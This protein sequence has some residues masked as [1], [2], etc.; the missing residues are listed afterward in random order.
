MSSGPIPLPGNIV[1]ACRPPYFAFG[2]P[3]YNKHNISSAKFFW[4]IV[5]SLI[6]EATWEEFHQS[7]KNAMK[8][9]Q[10]SRYQST[11]KSR[12]SEIWQ[13]IN[14]R[15]RWVIYLREVER[16]LACIERL[17]RESKWKALTVV[18]SNFREI[19]R[20]KL[21]GTTRIIME[22][23][24]DNVPCQSENAYQSRQSP[25]MNSTYSSPSPLP[26]SLSRLN[27]IAKPATNFPQQIKYI[28][29]SESTLLYLIFKHF[30]AQWQS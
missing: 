14:E 17:E 19:L 30:N 15:E 4:S 16:L 12:K 8:K 28:M 23:I 7:P 29:L 25:A 18:S 20:V 24:H 2:I 5:Y 6:V 11:F 9:Q 27:H 22:V 3:A 10:N 13:M 26:L 21:A 1:T